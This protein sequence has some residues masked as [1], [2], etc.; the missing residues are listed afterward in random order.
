MD[1][2]TLYKQLLLEESQNTEHRHE[3][4]AAT[5]QGEGKNPSCGDELILQLKV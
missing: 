4:D 5:H 2:Q 1:L 3:I